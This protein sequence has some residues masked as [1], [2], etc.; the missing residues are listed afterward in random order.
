MPPAFD[1][2][3]APSRLS[4]PRHVGAVPC[5]TSAQSRATRIAGSGELRARWAGVQR[6]GAPPPTRV[7]SG[8]TAYYFPPMSMLRDF[9]KPSSALFAV[10]GGIALGGI[11]LGCKA[12]PPATAATSGDAC[13][14]CLRS[15]GTWQPEANECTRKCAIQDISCFEDTCPGACAEDAC[16]DCFDAETCRAAGCTWHIE[17]EAAWCANWSEPA[18]E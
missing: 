10:L 1:T 14:A 18:A 7:A 5:A 8:S 9:W 6:P 15:G 13:Q 17:A 4:P 2:T 3:V 12:D 16:G 11:A